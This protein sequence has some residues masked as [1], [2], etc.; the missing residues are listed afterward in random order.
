MTT[1]AP[2]LTTFRRSLAVAGACAAL[3]VTA[4][5][6]AAA[7]SDQLSKV[8]VRYDDLNLATAAGVDVLYRRI[9]SAARTVCHDENSRDLGIAA[10]VRQCRESAIAQA[11]HEVNNP[12]LALVHAARVSRG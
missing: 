2:K 5:A 1:A 12:R 10:A 9:S 6:F 4:G 8:T 3:A 11:V 7:P